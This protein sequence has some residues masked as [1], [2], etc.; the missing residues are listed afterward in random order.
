MKTIHDSSKGQITFLDERFY[1]KDNIKFFPSV[2]TILDVFPKGYGF[3]QWLKDLGAN[4]D[5]VVKRSQEIGSNVHSA[6]DQYLQG[7]K[8]TWVGENK[9]PQYSLEEW[10]MFLKF[11]EFWTKY[12]PRIIANEVSLVDEELGYGGT[13]DLV[14]EIKDGDFSGIWLIDYKSGHSIY[15]SHFIQL[16][17]YKKLWN[18]ISKESQ[19]NKMGIFHLKATTRGED[20]TGR[21]IQGKGW[22]L[23][24]PDKSYD[25]LCSLFDHTFAIWKDENPEIKPKNMI[26]PD[27]AQWI[28]EVKS[29]K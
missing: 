24:E 23:A 20:K 11:V 21:Q 8:I 13:L 3:I 22:K 9:E 7:E 19:I 16:A 5:E 15:K 2:T 25:Y 4:A 10:L 27:A 14:C 28:K 26:Y 6:I 12:K 17:A 29:S 18:K 1:T